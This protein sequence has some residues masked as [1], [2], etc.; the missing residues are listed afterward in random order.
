MVSADQRRSGGVLESH[1]APMFVAAAYDVS[2]RMHDRSEMAGAIASRSRPTLAMVLDGLEPPAAISGE[3]S[4]SA[5]DRA[6]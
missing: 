2:R 6:R 1:L 5:N 3:L 4:V